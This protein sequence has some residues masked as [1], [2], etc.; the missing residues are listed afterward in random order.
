MLLGTLKQSSN[1]NTIDFRTIHFQGSELKFEKLTPDFIKDYLDSKKELD[2]GLPQ[3]FGPLLQ[4]TYLVYS[5]H[6]HDLTTQRSLTGLISYVGSSL[7][8]SILKGH[9][10]ITSKYM[11]L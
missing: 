6:V 7:V 3:S 4:T 5:G 8:I 10:Y 1:K 2:S 11:L 9:G